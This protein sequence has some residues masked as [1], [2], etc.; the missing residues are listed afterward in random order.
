MKDLIIITDQPITYDSCALIVKDS[1]KKLL[2][3]GD[4]PNECIYMKKK[5][6][7]FELWF[8][9]EDVIDNPEFFMEEVMEK[10]PNKKAYL[11][12]F[13]YTHKSVAKKMIELLKPLYGHM[14]I[15]SDESDK[16][17]GTADEFIEIYCKEN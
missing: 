3:L 7:G 11:T 2:L 1:F 16:W 17:Y 14:W 6:R 12:D 10:C 13:C 5:K 15:Q 9:P 8:T 4:E